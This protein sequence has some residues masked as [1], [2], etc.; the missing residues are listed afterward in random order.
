MTRKPYCTPDEFRQ[1]KAMMLG[2]KKIA[3]RE[4]SPKGK[5]DDTEQPDSR[6]RGEPQSSGLSQHSSCAAP[7]THRGLPAQR[8]SPQYTHIRGGAAPS[9]SFLGLSGAIGLSRTAQ[10]SR[11]GHWNVAAY[12]FRSA[13]QQMTGDSD[14]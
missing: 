8:S 9:G 11:R 2:G 10:F 13:F 1:F 5:Q 7:Q 3:S 12:R 4:S 6:S 14:V